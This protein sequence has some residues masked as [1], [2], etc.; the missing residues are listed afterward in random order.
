MNGPGITRVK[1]AGATLGIVALV[2]S[3]LYVFMTPYNRI[4]GVRIGGIETPA[5]AD[6]N[7]VNKVGIIQL[8]TGGFPPFVVNVVYSATEHGVITATRPDGGF[9]AKQAR[10]NPNGWIRIG[11]ATYAMQASEI[12]GDQRLPMLEAYGAKNNMSMTVPASGGVIQGV[13]EPLHTWEV[14][15]WT[16]R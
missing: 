15:F 6:W 13:A 2:A 3:V 16:P 9:W 4:A 11:G 8:K 1:I 7:T 5:P 12:I 14:F 10:A